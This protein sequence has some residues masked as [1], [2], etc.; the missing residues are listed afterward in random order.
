M[1]YTITKAFKDNAVDKSLVVEQAGYSSKQVTAA[2]GVELFTIK[3]TAGKTARVRL[4]T[5]IT[6]TLRDGT[7]DLWTL[8]GAGAELDL[9]G[10]PL[11][12][13]TDIRLH[14]SD[15]GSAWIIYR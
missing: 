11:Q 5:A 8:S 4:D 14:L 10:T 9:G 6:L 3:A 1:S 15:S 12:H 2:A 13:N 7:T